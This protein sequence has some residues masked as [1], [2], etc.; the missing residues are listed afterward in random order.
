VGGGGGGGLPESVGCW[1]ALK[2]WYVW[3]AF[4]PHHMAE[5]QRNGENRMKQC[6]IIW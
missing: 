2:L 6:N 3:V 4:G 5:T 1:K